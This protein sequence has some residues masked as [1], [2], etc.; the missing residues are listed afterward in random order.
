MRDLKEGYKVSRPERVMDSNIEQLIKGFVVF[1][2]DNYLL[3]KIAGFFI[4][5][6]TKH[7]FLS[8]SFFVIDMNKNSCVFAIWKV[9]IV[10][11]VIYRLTWIGQKSVGQKVFEIFLITIGLVVIDWIWQQ[12]DFKLA[13]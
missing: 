1:K 10:F 6:L 5:L 9:S 2:V 11:S 12:N 13:R 3:P 4:V 7:V 8:Y